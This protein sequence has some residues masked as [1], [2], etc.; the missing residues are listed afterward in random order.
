MNRDFFLGPDL[1]LGL[2]TGAGCDPVMELDRHGLDIHKKKRTSQ[3]LPPRSVQGLRF[4]CTCRV[5]VHKAPSAESGRGIGEQWN[6]GLEKPGKK[7]PSVV[8]PWPT[9]PRF[10]FQV[11]WNQGE[12][13][14]YQTR[15][16]EH[17]LGPPKVHWRPL[18]Y[19]RVW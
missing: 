6:E 10:F 7:S 1:D 16:R 8:F 15:H 11:L 2:R 13:S 14:D 3:R 5:S 19:R 9:G 12:L 17:V 18:A 4:P